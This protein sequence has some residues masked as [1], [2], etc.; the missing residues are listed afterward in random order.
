MPGYPQTTKQRSPFLALPYEI[1]HL[2]YSTLFPIGHQITVAGTNLVQITNR[3]EPLKTLW[4]DPKYETNVLLACRIINEEITTM[5][6]GR[7]AFFAYQEAKKLC[8]P[9]AR[10]EQF[11]AQL[12]PETAVKIQNLHIYFGPCTDESFVEALVPGIARFPHLEVSITLFRALPITTLQRLRVL[13]ERAVRLIAEARSGAVTVWDAKGDV[14]GMEMLDSILP[15]G[16]QRK[17]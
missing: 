12:R 5:F 17:T 3:H 2:I 11:L 9:P 14:G 1:R 16:Y 4:A 7:N 15:V 6:Y 10:C 13:I 8:S